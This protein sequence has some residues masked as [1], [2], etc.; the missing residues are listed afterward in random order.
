M[1]AETI[2]ECIHCLVRMHDAEGWEVVPRSGGGRSEFLCPGCREL[3]RSVTVPGLSCACGHPQEEHDL[4]ATRYCAATEAGELTR[5][6]ACPTRA[7]EKAR[8]YDRR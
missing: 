4:L 3:P 1:T 7:V 8:S 2:V 6:C 5:A